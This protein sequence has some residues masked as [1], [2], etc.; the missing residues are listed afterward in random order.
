MKSFITSGPVFAM[1]SKEDIFGFSKTRVKDE[2]TVYFI[3]SI[4]L[5]KNVKL[6]LC[7]HCS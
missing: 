4:C 1:F 7:K 2:T 3:L 6:P 5:S